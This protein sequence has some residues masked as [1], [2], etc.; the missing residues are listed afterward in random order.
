MKT[1]L[2]PVDF[3]EHSEYALEVAASIAKSQNAEIVVLHMMGIPDSFLTNDEK[4]EVFNA[5]YFMKLTKKRF[6]KLLDKD[7]L[8]DLEVSE[9]V[10]TNKVF[11]EINEVAKEYDADLIVMGSHGSS[12]IKEAFIG[13]NTE[14]VVR[15]SEV[16][17]LVIKDRIS[18]FE[19]KKAI[20]VTDFQ[21]ETLDSF[22]HS[23]KFFRIFGIEPKILFINIPE[24]F[25][26]T[27]EMKT[28]ASN[29]L[30]DA[31][32][33]HKGL[34]E[35]ITFYDD[36]TV[37][38]GVFNYCKENNI[39]IIAMPTHGRK[40]IGH[41]FMGSIGEDIANHSAIP[42]VTFKI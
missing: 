33:D 40:G 34:D 8:K 42:V 9:A 11:S 39:D 36:Y 19:L 31:S 17:V 41:F 2:V 4:Q 27:R 18:K 13:S 30:I 20:F 1:I 3:S 38:R 26:N 28:R 32:M 37:E 25:M 23:R 12:G 24:K 5:L 7:Y 14:K 21:L 22:L 35:A 29:F 10:K 15:T 16:P 6:D